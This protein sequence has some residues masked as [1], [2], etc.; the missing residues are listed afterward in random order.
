MHTEGWTQYLLTLGPSA[1]LT[2]MSLNPSSSTE[3]MFARAQSLGWTKWKSPT[4]AESGS[5]RWFLKEAIS[6]VFNYQLVKPET[7]P[8]LSSTTRQTSQ[9]SSARS[10]S[11]S[12]GKSSETSASD[13]PNN[14]ASRQRQAEFA[15]ELRQ[16]RQDGLEPGGVDGIDLATLMIPPRE[17]RPISSFQEVVT[18]LDGMLGFSSESA[19]AAGAPPVPPVPDFLANPNN[20]DNTTTPTDSLPRRRHTR[21]SIEE[22]IPQ[23]RYPSFAGSTA[24]NPRQQPP[25]IQ[26]PADIA[27][28]KMVIELGFPERDAKWA[29]KNTDTGESLDVEAAINLLLQRGA[30]EQEQEMD[31][32]VG[33]A[34]GQAS[35]GELGRSKTTSGIP[36]ESESVWRPAWRWA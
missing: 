17:E 31:S 9:S 33:A 10:R 12:P 1:V 6:R 14:V 13:D 15:A 4:T 24:A 21:P 32:A 22:K 2:L 11:S 5:T 26:D 3:S 28:N 20:N 35:G 34:Q 19:T 16:R 7:S 27:L 23:S 30:E 18:K 25:A 36:S 29:L 8:R